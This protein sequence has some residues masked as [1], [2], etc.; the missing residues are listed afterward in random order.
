MKKTKFLLYKELSFFRKK[1]WKEVSQPPLKYI[2]IFL[3]VFCFQLK[4]EEVKEKPKEQS[5]YR[6]ILDNY[7]SSRSQSSPY[8]GYNRV[9]SLSSG[10]SFYRIS[11]KK[12]FKPVSSA[13]LSFTQDIRKVE[14]LGDLQLRASLT[15]S[16]QERSKEISLELTPLFTFPEIETGFPIYFGFGFGF[17]FYPFYIIEKKPS[18]SFHSPF[19][20]GLR[21]FELYSNLGAGAELD[22]RMHFPLNELQ[23]YLESRLQLHL[24]F[25]F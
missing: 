3:I 18:F 6:Y 20:I 7:F 17:G 16:E 10:A 11:S 9:F 1:E 25:Q 24:I 14:K 4:A 13:F 23:F 8:S 5:S 19:L 2:L 12:Q 21:F 22:L 15:I